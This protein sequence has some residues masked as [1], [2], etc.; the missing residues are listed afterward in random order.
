MFLHL[1]KLALKIGIYFL[2]YSLVGRRTEATHNFRI[3]WKAKVQQPKFP[4]ALRQLFLINASL[5][6]VPVLP[7]AS[8]RAGAWNIF[9]N[10]F[11]EYATT[12]ETDFMGVC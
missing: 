2:L 11:E 6:A 1:K 5:R 8:G 9:R 7:K 12:N 3:L 4:K 10:N